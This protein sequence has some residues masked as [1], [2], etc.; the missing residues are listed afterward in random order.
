MTVEQDQ[1]DRLRVSGYTFL[2]ERV[3]IESIASGMAQFTGLD[4]DG[5]AVIQRRLSDP[6]VEPADKMLAH[7]LAHAGHALIRARLGLPWLDA[8]TPMSEA[9]RA[10]ASDPVLAAYWPEMA[11]AVPLAAVAQ[12][13]PSHDGD[14]AEQFAEAFGYI[15]SGLH[16]GRQ[17]PTMWAVYGG[18]IEAR[19]PQ[20]EAFFRGLG[21]RTFEAPA[22]APIAPATSAPGP[23][24]PTVVDIRAELPFDAANLPWPVISV[25]SSVTV[26]W[27]GGEFDV[28]TDDDAR[29]L[30]YAFAE[31]HI[32]KDWSAEI[33]GVQG[34]AGLMYAEVIAPSG[35][36]FITRDPDAVLWHSNTSEGNATSRPILVICGAEEAHLATAAQ[37]RALRTRI[38]THALP[39]FP[40]SHWTQTQCPGD[41]LRA[42]LAGHMN[43][44]DD[45][46]AEERRAE[47]IA[48][49]QELITP[50][51]VAM[52]DVETATVEMVR[53]LEAGEVIDDA[54][55]AELKARLDKLHAI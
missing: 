34:G 19:R 9:W 33:P 35:T 21:T 27:P 53:K 3:R 2:P 47:F 23:A 25:K 32:A 22:A 52:K 4:A 55:R 30:I 36:V 45:M 7:E 54:E 29:N 49:T 46:T 28:E 37:L 6:L 26:H 40:H 5:T 48:L 42:L 17:L 41:R 50:T 13:A 39:A 38:V 15:A 31:E 10:R 8:I 12:L 1:L 11:Y 18:D 16:A 51:I 43:V 24:G 44:E 20:L 14:P